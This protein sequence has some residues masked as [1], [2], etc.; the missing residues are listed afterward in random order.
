MSN[1]PNYNENNPDV[2]PDNTDNPII[3]GPTD[4]DDAVVYHRLDPSSPYYL[5]SND[6]PGNIICLVKLTGHN[7]EEWSRF[8]KLSLRGRRKYGFIDGSLAKQANPDFWGDWD[9]VQSTLVQWILNTIDSTQ[10]KTFPH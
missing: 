7:Y 9:A 4:P 6:N 8:M 1:P 2:D 5:S 10:R 3:P